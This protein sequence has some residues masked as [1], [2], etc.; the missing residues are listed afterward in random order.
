MSRARDAAFFC[1]LAVVWGLSFPAIAV[2]LEYLPPL[3]FAA[4]RYDVAAVLLLA[5][6]VV[7]V[8]AWRPAARGDVV[9]I[10]GG[11]V[12]L[13]AGNGLLFVGQQTVP[14][15][16]AAVLQALVP[17]VTAVWAFV[18]LGEGLSSRGLAGVAV[19][20]VGVSLVIQ[21]DPSNLLGGDTAGRVVI[22][23]QVVSVALGGV[24]V[25]RANASLAR[26]PLTGWAM[27][28]GAVVLHVVSVGIGERPSSSL[29]LDPTAVAAVVYL[30]V[31]STALAFLIYFT[32]LAEYGAFEAALVSYAVPVVATLVG[33]VV[34]GETMSAL[35]VLG[36]GLVLVG[37][38][39][40]KR[41]AVD[42]LLGTAT[43][44]V[45]P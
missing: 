36:F 33:V 9:A 14:S 42:D 23:G 25:Q 38:V 29:A 2:G 41:E 27:A 16:V 21:P 20:F 43:N 34:L 18:L 37:F 35:T 12:F 30:G 11:G 45:R 1:T 31:F 3:V 10:V 24:I 39:L 5:Y 28:V 44:V 4:L 13:V 26:V 15:G 22:V 19:A 6:A 17:V 8:D 32:I 7:R 40:L